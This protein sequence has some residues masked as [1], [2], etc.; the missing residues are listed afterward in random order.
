MSAGDMAAIMAVL[1]LPP[2][3]SRNN[4][5]NTESRYGIK[6]AFF[7]FLLFEACD[8]NGNDMHERKFST[9]SLNKHENPNFNENR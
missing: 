8:T 5:V 2:K 9:P 6:S 1:E 4:H 7:D 3:F